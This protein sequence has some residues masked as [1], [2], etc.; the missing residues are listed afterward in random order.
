[1]NFGTTRLW[2]YLKISDPFTCQSKLRLHMNEMDMINIDSAIIS[3]AFTF[4]A[5]LKFSWP[6]CLSI[7]FD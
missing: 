6:L 2:L 7:L 4:L 1:M 5:V 3:E